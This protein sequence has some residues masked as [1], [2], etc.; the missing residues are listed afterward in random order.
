MTRKRLPLVIL[1]AV[2]AC[3][4]VAGIMPS[5][6]LVGRFLIVADPINRPVDAVV[7]L[8]GG[9]LRIPYAAELFESQEA[10][11]FVITETGKSI[12]TVRESISA[13]DANLAIER[14]VPDDA[15]YVT[16]LAETSTMGEAEVVRQFAEKERVASIIVVTDPFHTR[17]TRMLFRRAFKGMDVDLMVRPVAGH[18]YQSCTWWMDPDL[19]LITVLEY[20]KLAGSLFINKQ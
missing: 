9:D 17:R 12:P 6:C 20:G 1:A 8:S 3:L 2:G 7:V 19:R 11:W 4:L 13:Q 14:G 16:A 5:L 15:I 10:G 18:P